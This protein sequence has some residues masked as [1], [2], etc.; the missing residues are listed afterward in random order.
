MTLQEI[1]DAVNDGKRVFWQQGN[2][3]VKKHVGEE[4]DI[5]TLQHVPVENWSIVCSNNGHT[6]GLT[7]TDEVTINGKEK[8]FYLE[9]ENAD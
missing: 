1:K 2:Y 5:E 6:I 7:W 9:G 8:D 4:L 3:E